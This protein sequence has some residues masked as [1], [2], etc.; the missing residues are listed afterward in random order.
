MRTILA[1]ACLLIATPAAA[2]VT[3][4][5][6]VTLE[7]NVTIGL[8]V[9]PPAGGECDL[10]L[11]FA[12]NQGANCMRTIYKPGGWDR[13][14][15]VSY[16]HDPSEPKLTTDCD[17]AGCGNMPHASDTNAFADGT[18]SAMI[19]TGN[20]TGGNMT[21]WLVA[22]NPDG[23]GNNLYGDGTTCAEVNENEVAGMGCVGVAV[24]ISEGANQFSGSCG[25]SDGGA[26]M[27][28]ACEGKGTDQSYLERINTCTG[29]RTTLSTST[30]NLSSLWDMYGPPANC[31]HNRHQADWHQTCQWIQVCATLVQ[32]GGNVTI[33]GTV[34]RIGKASGWVKM[35]AENGD[36]GPPS[37]TVPH[38]RYLI[39]TTN[40][41]PVARHSS[42]NTTGQIGIAGGGI[43]GT[44][45]EGGATNLRRP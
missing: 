8:G 14:S 33:T 35:D 26:Y 36:P 19:L 4:S 11:S 22:Y 37:G 43:N 16:G 25:A 7:G 32:G 10:P 42:I 41:G 3:L 5:G 6:S 20:L 39:G 45:L 24:L 30:N 44:T 18:H 31:D 15:G 17:A 13:R 12:G 38:T 23:V 40:Y 29:A 9:D 34:H 1:L 21:G 2:Q 27:F 28:T